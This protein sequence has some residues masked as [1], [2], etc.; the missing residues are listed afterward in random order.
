MNE[1]N[2]FNNQ[3]MND[4]Q[5][6]DM[7]NQPVNYE[8]QNFQNVPENNAN[9]EEPKKG[10]NWL[11]IIL[12]ILVILLASYILYDKVIKKEEVKEP[13]KQVIDKN[14]ESEKNDELEKIDKSRGWYYF[15]DVASY[16][17]T[18]EKTKEKINV[19][20]KYPVININSDDAKRINEKTKKEVL[21]KNNTFINSEHGKTFGCSETTESDFHAYINYNNAKKLIGYYDIDEFKIKETE[22]EILMIYQADMESTGVILCGAGGR[23]Y[24]NAVYVISKETGKE[25]TQKEI[26]ESYGY[27]KLLKA[28]YLNDSSE[29]DVSMEELKEFESQ[30]EDFVKLIKFFKFG[31]NIEA[32]TDMLT[33]DSANH[34]YYDGNKF[35]AFE[36]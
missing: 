5:N 16:E 14:D 32:S 13:E 15:E 25:L 36:E 23:K 2:N 6:L 33:V 18:N 35:K 30:N 3:N 8:Q 29:T 10:N 7:N 9:E 24:I 11:V 19:V 4:N 22:K 17:V 20:Y 12:L 31:D 21:E 27:D 34:Y 28:I 26:V 1:E